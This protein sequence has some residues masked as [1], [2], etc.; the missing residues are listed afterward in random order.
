MTLGTPDPCVL[1]AIRH[2]LPRTLGSAPALQC[3]K[4]EE[5]GGIGL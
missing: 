2:G 1:A 5:H 3:L 4:L